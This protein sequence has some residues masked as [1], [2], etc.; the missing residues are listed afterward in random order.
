MKF[1]NI[2]PI[3]I[4]LF[5]PI[6][7]IANEVILTIQ[8]YESMEIRLLIEKAKEASPEERIKIEG[9]IRKKIAKAHR[10]TNARG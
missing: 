9:L 3:G 4:V 5:T 2:L 1:K 8:P 6:L 10:E 7:S